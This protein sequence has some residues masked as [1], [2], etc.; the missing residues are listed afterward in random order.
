MPVAKLQNHH[1]AEKDQRFIEYN[2]RIVHFLQRAAVLPL[3]ALYYLR[4][5]RPSVRPSIC[6]SHAGIVSKRL[7][8]ARCSLHCQIAKCV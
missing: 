1:T 6:L 7:H 3:Q 5:F 8:V 4:Q 2:N